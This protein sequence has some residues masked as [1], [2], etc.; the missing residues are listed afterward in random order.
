MLLKLQ[1][2]KKKYFEICQNLSSLVTTLS[3]LKFEYYFQFECKI[4]I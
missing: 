3:K 2:Y 4:I 1:N